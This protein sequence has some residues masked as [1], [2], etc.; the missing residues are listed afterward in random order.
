[1]TSQISA[2]EELLLR[3]EAEQ[4]QILFKLKQKSTS[5]ENEMAR[6][7][8]FIGLI[9]ITTLF[10]DTLSPVLLHTMRKVINSIQPTTYRIN[11]PFLET[12]R[13]QSS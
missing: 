13:G 4:N 6:H 2:L 3:H 1:M 9:F 10:V 12:T 8:F 11:P 5:A 7:K